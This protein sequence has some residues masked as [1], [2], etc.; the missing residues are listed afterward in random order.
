MG[1]GAVNH[2]DRSH[3][4]RRSKSP[5]AKGHLSGLTVTTV[6]RLAVA[7]SNHFDGTRTPATRF[8]SGAEEQTNQV[9]G[10]QHIEQRQQSEQP[11]KNTV[12][13][14]IQTDILQE[15]LKMGELETE[16]VKLS[17]EI[18]SLKLELSRATA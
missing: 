6:S 15:T 11:A 2:C 4:L 1:S 18:A 3:S 10:L 5:H 16:N 9:H 14:H 8:E 7:S 12:D 13:A 17:D